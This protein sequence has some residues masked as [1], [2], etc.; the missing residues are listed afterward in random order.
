MINYTLY[1]NY[2]YIIIEK[3][4]ICINNKEIEFFNVFITKSN[5]KLY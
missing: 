4:N 2:I 1:L 3:I 5:K